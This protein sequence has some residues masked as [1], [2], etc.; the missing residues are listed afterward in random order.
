[1][2]NLI[3]LA[4]IVFGIYYYS[5]HSGATAV[6]NEIEFD[7]KD[8]IFHDEVFATNWTSK[9]KTVTG[10]VREINQENMSIM[11]IVTYSIVATT[12][13]YSNPDK[14]EIKHVRHG[15]QLLSKQAAGKPKGSIIIYHLIPLDAEVQ[16]KIESIKIGDNF[17]IKARISQSGKL[18]SP[19]AV[20]QL[21][22]YEP[23]EYMRAKMEKVDNAAYQLILLVESIN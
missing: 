23:S 20:Y 17:S 15:Y 1:M 7:G 5:T 10:Y 22:S 18:K 14:V 11:P 3:I 21:S 12:G 4:A 8:V 9:T 2:K 19:R 16:K 13:D 6:A